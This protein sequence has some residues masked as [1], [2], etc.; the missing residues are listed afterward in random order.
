LLLS[1]QGDA[2][3]NVIPP[4]DNLRRIQADS[5]LRLIPVPSPTLGF[6]LYNQRDP[7]DSSRP[8][9]S[10]SD[11]RVRR[12]ITLGLD[13]PALIQVVFGSYAEVPYGPAS[14]LLWIRHGTPKPQRQ[15]LAEARKLLAAAGWTDK[16]GDGILDRTGRSLRLR[17]SFPSTSAVRRQLALLIQE[18]LR[19]L[20]IGIELSQLEFPV[21]LERR[22]AGNF[23]IDFA[24]TS[25]D[26]SPSGLSQGW[27]C[28]GGTNVARYCDPRVDSLIERA[29]LS[30][31]NSEEVWHAVLKQI[32]EDAP[33]TFLYAPT[34]VSVVRRR[35]GNVTITPTSSWQLVR[36]WSV[37]P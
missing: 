28:S 14:P 31:V 11:I 12:A 13:R 4:L 32:E 16:D 6:L 8:H 5:S 25:Q 19:Q 10:L 33:A 34:Y 18:Q 27:S 15:N 17:L 1:G 20:G 29:V 37:G 2:L 36:N 7:A 22:T 3:D 24:S 9:P 21:W 35:F 30:R 26:P 23:D